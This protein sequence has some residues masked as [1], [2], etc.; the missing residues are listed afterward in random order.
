ME[1][2]GYYREN[3]VHVCTLRSVSC[4]L[5]KWRAVS[6][7]TSGT[8]LYHQSLHSHKIINQ[9][10]KAFAILW[11]GT[12]KPCHRGLYDWCLSVTVYTASTRDPFCRNQNYS[13]YRFDSLSQPLERDKVLGLPAVILGRTLS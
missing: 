3:F 2:E 4:D 10:N 1:K 13:A 11:Q 9:L 6:C 5:L 8:I 12:H 7:I